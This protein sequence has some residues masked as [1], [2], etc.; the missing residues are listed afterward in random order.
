MNVDDATALPDAEPAV[1]AILADLT[2]SAPR[3]P[4]NGE[5]RS[6]KPN[7]RPHAE[8]VH[9]ARVVDEVLLDCPLKI[10]PRVRKEKLEQLQR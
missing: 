1:A 4:R 3:K 10:T 5:N 2:N 7:W 8:G 9:L 6:G